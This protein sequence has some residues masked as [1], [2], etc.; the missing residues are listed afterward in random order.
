MTSPPSSKLVTLSWRVFRAFAYTQTHYKQAEQHRRLGGG[1]RNRQVAQSLDPIAEA[2]LKFKE[3][4]VR[5]M[6]D[7]PG[8]QRHAGKEIN[9][10]LCSEAT[11]K[12]L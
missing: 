12:I 10:T 8:T 1:S 9:I 4:K 11:A 6:D 3:C 7:G 5:H 2:E